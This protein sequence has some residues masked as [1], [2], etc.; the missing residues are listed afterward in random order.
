[1]MKIQNLRL[2]FLSFFS[3]LSCPFFLLANPEGAQIEAG[4]ATIL[5]SQQKELNITQASE[6][7]IINWELDP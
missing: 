2:V 4:S 5:S 1:M 7:A 3:F 6:K